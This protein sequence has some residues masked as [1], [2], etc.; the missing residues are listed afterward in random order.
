MADTWRLITHTFRIRTSRLSSLLLLFLTFLDVLPYGAGQQA[1]GHQYQSG[2]SR[3]GWSGAVLAVG[4]RGSSISA[5][6]RCPSTHRPVFVSPSAVNEQHIDFD[7]ISM[8]L[9][10]PKEELM[11]ESNVCLT[12]FLLLLL[13]LVLLVRDP[14]RQVAKLVFH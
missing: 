14:P 8:C 10:L 12:V 1:S 2:S 9:Q 6:R 11:N 5:S 4:A 13:L 7:A 3:A